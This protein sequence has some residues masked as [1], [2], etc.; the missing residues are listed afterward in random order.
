[1]VQPASHSSDSDSAI[2]LNISAVERDTGVPKDTLRIW[3]RRYNFP[4]PSRDAHGDRA[5]TREQVEKLRLIKRLLDQGH[6]PGKIVGLDDKALRALT[7]APAETPAPRQDITTYLRLLASHQTS[8]L[9]GQLAQALAR[10]G[11][12]HFVLDTVAP[13]T[14]A[15]GDFWA[16]GK[17]AVFVEHAFSELIQNML[18][19]AIAGMQ[20][21]GSAPRILLTSLPNEQHALGLLMLEAMLAV[22]NTHCISLGT[23]TPPTDIVRAVKAHQ[24]DIV[25][26]SFSAAYSESKAMDA[27]AE[28]RSMLPDKVLICAGGHGVSRIRRRLQGVHFV[29]DFGAMAELIRD[30][31]TQHAA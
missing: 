2:L 22:E 8:E 15:I 5:Y 18:R 12:Q 24:V 20:T 16:Q 11:L 21:Q 26:L 17:I 27:L 14:R 7:A 31:R 4:Q 19:S 3:E 6:R 28:L 25:S 10:Q 30:W 1:M 9:R 29:G 23:E 13:L